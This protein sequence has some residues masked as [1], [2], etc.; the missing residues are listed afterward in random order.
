ML[1]IASCASVYV[2][3]VPGGPGGGGGGAHGKTGEIPAETALRKEAVQ[4]IFSGFG[5]KSCIDNKWLPSIILL[6]SDTATRGFCVAICG[7]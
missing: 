3:A 1:C 2:G 6:E 4:S 5:P 7:C